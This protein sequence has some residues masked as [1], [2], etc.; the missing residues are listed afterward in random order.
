VRV[1]LEGRVVVVSPHVDDAVFSLGA[2]IAR[3]KRGG[4]RV[5]VLTVFS[6]DPA[7]SA[8]A[9]KWDR[10]A[11]F[12]TVGQA[13]TARRVEDREAC[14]IVGA[15]PSW[16]RFLGGGYG[17]EK[18]ADTIWSA[19]ASAVANAD[20]VLI[21]GFPLTN[22]DHAWLARLLAERPVPCV[23]TGLYAE[24][25]YRYMVRAESPRPVVPPLLRQGM[26]G[27]IGWTGTTARLSD[28]RLKRKA[29]LAYASQLP[30]LG[31]AAMRGRKLRLML[32]HEA[33]HRGEAIAWLPE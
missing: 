10:R 22:E 6:G 14:R 9:N 28:R 26:S 24:Q 31:L 21:P 5:E 30:M 20:A 11:G 32:L 27:A 33:L 15:E 19:V 1:S 7:S 3:A 2:T 29:I 13:M 25:P 4:A 23:R 17:G 16:L 12:G 8:P 18:N